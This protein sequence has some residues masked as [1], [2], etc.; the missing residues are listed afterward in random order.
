M[1]DVAKSAKEAYP[2]DL[3]VTSKDD[4][5]TINKPEPYFIPF[6]ATE[7]TVKMPLRI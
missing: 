5:W 6:P 4:V 7:V 1:E 2:S 3:V